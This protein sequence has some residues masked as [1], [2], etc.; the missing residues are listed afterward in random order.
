VFQQSPVILASSRGRVIVAWEDDRKDVDVYAQRVDSTGYLGNQEPIVTGVQDVPGDEGGAIELTW[1]ASDLDGAS[2]APIDSYRISRSVAPE[3][4]P[5]DAVGSAPA[6]GMA[7]YRFVVPTLSDSVA[8][9]NPY[10]WILVQAVAAG[11]GASLDSDPNRGYSVDNLPPQAPAGLS[12]V[13]LAAATELHWR[14]NRNGDLAGYRLY[15]GLGAEFVPDAGSLIATPVDTAYVDVGPTGQFYKLSAVDVH[16]NESAYT[17]IGPENTT[18]VRGALIAAFYLAPPWPSP[19]TGPSALSFG[20]AREGMLTLEVFDQ[21]GRR[22]RSLVRGVFPAGSLRAT[23]DG[24]DDAGRPVASGLYFVRLKNW[25][26]AL[27]RR[28]VVV[29]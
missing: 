19:S 9:S 23:W 21:Q 25:E 12:A 17:S 18:D 7:S 6:V 4:S 1:D 22:V 16:G 8:G 14:A 26:R 27:T 20:L 2:T 15:R 3:G 5:W 29:R 11:S 28:L 10:T 13:T 24:C